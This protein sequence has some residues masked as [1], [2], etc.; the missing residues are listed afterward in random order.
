MK[1]FKEKDMVKGWFV[2]DFEPTCFNTTGVE[3]SVKRY[4]KNDSESSHHHKIASEITFV[5]NGKISMNGI[6]YSQGDI[7]LVEPGESILFKVLED[8]ETVVVK[9]PCVKGDKYVDNDDGSDVV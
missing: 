6:E 1:I 9:V 8:S 3:V 2:G 5:L 7:I 4:K